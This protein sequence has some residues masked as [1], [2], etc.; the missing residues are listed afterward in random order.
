MKLQVENTQAQVINLSSITEH[1]WA[2]FFTCKVKL[3]FYKCYL[4]LLMI[5]RLH[6]MQLV[7]SIVLQWAADHCFHFRALFTRYFSLRLVAFYLIG[8][9]FST[10]FGNSHV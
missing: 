6:A 8:L 10:I 5:Y 2:F 1:F 3:K 9:T 4:F 7:T